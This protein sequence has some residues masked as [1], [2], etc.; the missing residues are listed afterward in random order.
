MKRFLILC[1]RRTKQKG[2]KTKKQKQNMVQA[3]L[4]AT[5]EAIVTQDQIPD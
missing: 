4:H 2:K 3:K 5:N 1:C